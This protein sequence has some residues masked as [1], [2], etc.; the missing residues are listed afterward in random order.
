MPQPI[1][2]PL[3]LFAASCAAYAQT[4]GAKLEF[5]VASIKVAPPPDLR[6]S[7]MGW[8]GG[9]IPGILACSRPRTWTS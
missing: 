9:R 1:L 2:R 4:A 6:G 5:E 7:T 3:L 8:S